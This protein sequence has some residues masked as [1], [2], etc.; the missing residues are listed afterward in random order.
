[1]RIFLHTS[2]VHWVLHN[3]NALYV[4]QYYNTRISFLHNIIF[5]SI[6]IVPYVCVKS[7]QSLF[8]RYCMLICK[9][10]FVCLNAMICRTKASC[11]FLFM[12]LAQL[13]LLRFADLL[14][15][16]VLSYRYMQSGLVSSLIAFCTSVN[17]ILCFYVRTVIYLRNKNT[18]I[19]RDL[20]IFNLNNSIQGNRACGP[21]VQ[22]KWNHNSFTDSYTPRGVRTIK[23]PILPVNG[24]PV[25]HRD[26]SSRG[27]Q[28]LVLRLKEF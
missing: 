9:T 8:S 7:M 4:L 22:K 11:S 26:G 3:L 2:V 21:V 25:Q 6:W 13:L 12:V 10:F 28:T 20:N 1:L 18:E 15:S 23:Q 19:R 16:S 24:K 17:H 14:A 27:V 5:Y